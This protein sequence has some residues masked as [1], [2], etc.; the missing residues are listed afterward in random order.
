MFIL[1]TIFQWIFIFLFAVRFLYWITKQKNKEIEYP[2]KDL[3]IC[4]LLSCLFAV[5][6]W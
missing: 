1:L 6:K 2:A 5:L 4:A 3:T